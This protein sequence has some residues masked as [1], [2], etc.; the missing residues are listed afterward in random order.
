MAAASLNLDLVNRRF[1]NGFI[2]DID[3]PL[4]IIGS[5]DVI[6]PVVTFADRRHLIV[7]LFA[8][9]NLL[10]VGDDT[11]CLYSETGFE[12]ERY[13]DEDEELAIDSRTCVPCCTLLGMT[14]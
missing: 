2:E 12:I 14:E 9:L 3:V 13:R 1:L 7:I 11:F 5:G 8:E 10:K 4:R 6:P